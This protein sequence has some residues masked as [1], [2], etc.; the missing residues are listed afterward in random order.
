[1][2]QY[3]ALIFQ[4]LTPSHTELLILSPTDLFSFFFCNFPWL[5]K[6]QLHPRQL[7]RP[8]HL[9]IIFKS[10]FF[11]PYTAYVICEL[12][13]SIIPLNYIQNLSTCP[14]FYY[15]LSGLSHIISH[16]IVNRSLPLAFI[17]ALPPL[18]SF[19]HNK[20]ILLSKITLL[21]AKTKTLTITA[22]A[23]PAPLPL[24]QPPCSQLP[25]SASVISLFSFRHVR[26]ASACGCALSYFLYL[27]CSSFR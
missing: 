18:L 1:M 11:S 21:L 4:T 6:W 10:S 22:K 5:S 12:N 23:L 19:E 26:H 15:Y 24:Y 20:V 14:H 16:F 13:L 3:L 7:H 9:E 2:S 8:S 25:P 17:F 27:E